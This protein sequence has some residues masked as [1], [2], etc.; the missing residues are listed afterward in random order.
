MRACFLR[1]RLRSVSGTALALA[2]PQPPPA[3]PRLDGAAGP[4]RLVS[5]LLR[6][7]VRE[8]RRRGE[9]H[10]GLVAAAAELLAGQ[11]R[12]RRHLSAAVGVGNA[13]RAAPRSA[14]GFP[15]GQVAAT[16]RRWCRFAT[17]SRWTA[18]RCATAR[19]GWRS[20]FSTAPADTM[21]AGRAHPRGR[22][23]L[24]PRQHA[25][26]ARQPGAR[27]RRAAAQLPAA[28]PVLAR[29]GGR[30]LRPRR[31]GRRLQG[32]RRRRR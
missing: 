24:Q 7:R 27:A 22:R 12:P 11:R 10:P 5:R 13:A 18:S 25:Q 17:S 14:V 19:R 1:L 31:R 26:H 2:A 20:C 8:R 15:A 9:L 29:Q 28:V 30:E 23:A 32:S 6:R 16:P 4:R 21:D 3:E